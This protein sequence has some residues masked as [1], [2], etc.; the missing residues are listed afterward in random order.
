[1]R[2]LI[3]FFSFSTMFAQHQ[4]SIKTVAAPTKDNPTIQVFLQNLKLEEEKY[5]QEEQLDIVLMTTRLRKIF[6]SSPN[7]DKYLIKGVAAISAPYSEAK[8]GT[9]I[10]FASL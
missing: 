4:V 7:Y 10:S 8:E 6:Y 1:M 3:F 5:P 9:F 2:F